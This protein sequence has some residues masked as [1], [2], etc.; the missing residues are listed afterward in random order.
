MF[1]FSGF[2][3]YDYLFIIRYMES[4]HVGFPIRISAGQWIFAPHRSF[5]QL[6]TS[7]FGSQ[8]QGIHPALFLLNRSD[9]P[10]S[11]WASG[12]SWFSLSSTDSLLSVRCLPIQR[13]IFRCCV[14]DSIFSFYGALLKF[15]SAMEMRGFEPLTP[16]LQGR[17]S[18]N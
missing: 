4:V 6:V 8:C 14:F 3:P 17:C 5:S 1:Q 11:V 10:I 12:S 13:F 16:C 9:S 18:P 2:P 15:I 7:F